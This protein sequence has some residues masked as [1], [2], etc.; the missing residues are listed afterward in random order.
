MFKTRAFLIA[1]PRQAKGFGRFT[2][3]K[4]NGSWNGTGT[5]G[6][7]LGYWIAVPAS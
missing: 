1:G 7:C 2:R 5:S 4:G 6:V 3:A